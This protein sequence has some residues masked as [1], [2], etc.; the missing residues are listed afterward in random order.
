MVSNGQINGADQCEIVANY[1]RRV[2]YLGCI[3]SYKKEVCGLTLNYLYVCVLTSCYVLEFLTLNY[4]II[5][6]FKG[7]IISYQLQNNS[8]GK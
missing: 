6:L 7:I 4:F 3:S 2:V 8:W 1:I 5:T